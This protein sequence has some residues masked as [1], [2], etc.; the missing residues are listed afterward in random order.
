MSKVRQGEDF[1]HLFA[2]LI[3]REPELPEFLRQP[4]ASQTAP[5]PEF[6]HD[7]KAAEDS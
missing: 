5:A 6:T 2:D 4:A 1:D 7:L 3:N